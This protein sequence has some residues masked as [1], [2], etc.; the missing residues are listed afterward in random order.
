MKHARFISFQS[1]HIHCIQSPLFAPIVT[2]HFI[3]QASYK[4]PF[5]QRKNPYIASRYKNL[6]ELLPCFSY[7]SFSA[8]R[9]FLP[10]LLIKSSR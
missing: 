5:I 4:L 6:P 3:T 7:S 1:L 9:N 2:S 10:P 8:S